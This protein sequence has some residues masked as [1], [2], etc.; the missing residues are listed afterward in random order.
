[1]SSVADGCLLQSCGICC[2]NVVDRGLSFMGCG[3]RWW[4]CFVGVESVSV[5]DEFLVSSIDVLCR[6]SSYGVPGPSYYWCSSF[7][8]CVLVD[9]AGGLNSSTTYMHCM[10]DSMQTCLKRRGTQPMI[11][12]RSAKWQ[13]LPGRFVLRFTVEA[14]S[15]YPG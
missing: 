3:R 8:H 15:K 11:Q 1:V 13:F 6:R 7:R 5:V 9:L 14:M 4:W 10:F 2:E 12:S